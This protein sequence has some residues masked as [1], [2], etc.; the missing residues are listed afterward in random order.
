M[1]LRMTWTMWLVLGVISFGSDDPNDS[2]DELVAILNSDLQLSVNSPDSENASVADVDT[3]ET[4]NATDAASIA[5][6][7][8]M[9]D[10]VE[11]FQDVRQQFLFEQIKNIDEP[12]QNTDSNDLDILIE[13]VNLLQIPR[14]NMS[15]D[16]S[17]ENLSP[18]EDMEAELSIQEQGTKALQIHQNSNNEIASILAENIQSALHPLQLADV[19]YRRG[20]YRMAFQCYQ[21]V[22]DRFGK[23]NLIDYQW[24]FFQMANCC[25]Q[26]DPQKAIR[27]YSELLEAYPNSK[28]SAVALSR[29]QMIEW[30]QNNRIEEDYFA[31]K[32]NDDGTE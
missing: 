29:Q 31:A 3:L 7:E 26:E 5:S 8:E 24:I 6:P 12:E 20:E 28:W 14:N 22:H 25:R 2:F 9:N 18:D 17:K 30:E 10:S 11:V 15:D 1:K 23:E 27:L 21:Y 32:A 13:K 16:M 4:E 19:L